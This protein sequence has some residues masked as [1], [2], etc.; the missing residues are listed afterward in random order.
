MIRFS[1]I[2]G[3][4]AVAAVLTCASASVRPPVVPEP[5]SFEQT[6]GSFVLPA[7]LTVGGPAKEASAVVKYLQNAGFEAKKGGNADFKVEIDAQLKH[8]EYRL[9]VTP[10]GVSVQAADN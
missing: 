1:T 9:K 2:L 3:T 10:E 8:E 4:V 6:A 7:R 5:V